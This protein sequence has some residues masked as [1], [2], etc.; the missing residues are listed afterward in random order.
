MDTHPYI[1]DFE[2]QSVRRLVYFDRAEQEEETPLLQSVVT[3][4]E[5]KQYFRDQAKILGRGWFDQ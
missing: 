1:R 2:S 4:D 3:W 5:V